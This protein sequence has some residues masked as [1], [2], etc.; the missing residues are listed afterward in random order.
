MAKIAVSCPLCWFS[1]QVDDSFIGTVAKCRQ[2]GT[3]FKITLPQAVLPTTTSAPVP[4]ANLNIAAN[5]MSDL[6]KNSRTASASISRT[7]QSFRAPYDELCWYCNL[8]PNPCLPI[9]VYKFTMTFGSISNSLLD[10]EE[11]LR[12]TIPDVRA[13]AVI[14]GSNRIITLES[15]RFETGHATLPNAFVVEIPRCRNCMNSHEKGINFSGGKIKSNNAHINLSYFYHKLTSDVKTHG[16][17]RSEVEELDRK[18]NSSKT[19][20]TLKNL[21]ILVIIGYVILEVFAF[22][23]SKR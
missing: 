8:N 6:G 3:Q 12:P 19:R 22:F 1:G 10:V 5:L 4:H 11:A 14:S 2:C 18:Q 17:P 23:L 20:E 16:M 7:A 21:V 13:S 15:K 9:A